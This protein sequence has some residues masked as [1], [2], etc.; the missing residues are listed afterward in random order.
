MRWDLLGLSSKL[1]TGVY[2]RI[3]DVPTD[4]DIERGGT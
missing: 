2:F 4:I 1:Q 3:E